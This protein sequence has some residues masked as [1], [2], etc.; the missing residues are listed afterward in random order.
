MNLE[1][2]NVFSWDDAKISLEFNRGRIYPVKLSS[3]KI[4]ADALKLYAGWLDYTK[5]RPEGNM[6][7]VPV[8]AVGPVLIIGHSDPSSHNPLLPNWLTQHVLLT[9]K[10]HREILD[11][12]R[13]RLGG[14]LDGMHGMVL[15]ERNPLAGLKPV[16]TSREDMFTFLTKNLVVNRVV[17]EMLVNVSTK[18]DGSGDAEIP[19]GFAEAMQFFRGSALLADLRQ[20][21]VNTTI[22][23]AIPDTTRH[24]C[25]AVGVHATSA[26]YFIAVPKVPNYAFIDTV[27]S[28]VSQAN[29]KPIHLLLSPSSHLNGILERRVVQRSAL[30]E[31]KPEHVAPPAKDLTK[32]SITIDPGKMKELNPKDITLSNEQRFHWSI[33]KAFDLGGSD[34]HYEFEAGQGRIRVRVDGQLRVIDTVSEITIRGILG[35]ARAG[36]IKGFTQNTHDAQDARAT[37]R[38]GD[39]LINLRANLTPHRSDNN[40]VMVLRLLPKQSNLLKIDKLGIPDRS[41]IILHRAISAQQGLVF[42]TGPTGSGKTTTL[43]ACLS[44]INKPT[45]KINTIE[46]PVEIELEGATQS[47]VDDSRNISFDTLMQAVLRQ[48]PDVILIGEIRS[49]ETARLALQAAQTGHLVF[50]TL[51][52]NDEIEAFTRMIDLLDDRDQ[53]PVLAKACLLSQSQRLLAK[54][55]PHCSTEEP[56]TPRE[57]AVFTKHKITVARVKRARPEGCD[58]CWHGY[59]GRVACMALLPV[60]DAFAKKLSAGADAFELREEADRAGFRSLYVEALYKVAEGVT[61][62]EQAEL[63]RNTWADFDFETGETTL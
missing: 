60:T 9:P 57:N 61:T 14:L 37:I 46:D 41:K 22:Q 12:M 34:I 17:R 4:A 53:L 16:M 7:W 28:T 43:Y 39:A 19:E 55:C 24:M 63:W 20:I 25:K 11:F 21:E 3:T 45:V 5:H 47:M 50:A 51:H 6:P 36:G 49:K 23:Q 29:R 48:D 44:E 40:Q 38:I 18:A 52:T 42:V 26:N 13:D 59:H 62:F 1:P 8:G 56:L 15:P 54:V 35:V 33:W 27:E 58:Q 2:E 31:T 32:A 30:S 10:Q